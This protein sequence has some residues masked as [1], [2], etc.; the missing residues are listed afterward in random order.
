MDDFE[1]LKSRSRRADEFISFLTVV[2]VQ[3]TA[4]EPTVDSEIGKIGLIRTFFLF[5]VGVEEV[6]R[7]FD[8]VGDP[9]FERVG[10]GFQR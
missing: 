7:L 6:H 8:A 9:A 5:R 2:D 1:N 4:N 3:K 10:G